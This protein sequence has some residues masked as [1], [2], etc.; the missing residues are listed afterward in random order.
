[1]SLTRRK[2]NLRPWDIKSHENKTLRPVTNAVEISRSGQHFPRPT[3]FEEPFYTPLILFIWFLKA[4]NIY[5]I[6]VKFCLEM[7]WFI[8]LLT[9][10]WWLDSWYWTLCS[11]WKDGISRLLQWYC[12]GSS[13]CID[14]C[15]QHHVHLGIHWMYWRFE[16]KYLPTEICMLSCL[17]ILVQVCLNF[18]IVSSFSSLQKDCGC[19]RKCRDYWQFHPLE[20]L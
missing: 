18:L 17:M 20:G 13:L 14:H 12:F 1:M 3:F 8:S 6:L 9:A 4:L 7:T 16:G 2:I 10:D 19:S 15:R 5:K 11:L